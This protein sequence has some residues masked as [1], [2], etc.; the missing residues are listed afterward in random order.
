VNFNWYR[1]LR[2]SAKPQS[3]RD[4]TR[5][6]F[7]SVSYWKLCGKGDSDRKNME[8]IHLF[9]HIVNMSLMTK[10]EREGK[11]AMAIQIMNWR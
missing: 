11:V 10:I 9:I 6:R 8:T 7:T 4:G 1:P 3:V 2:R 5:E